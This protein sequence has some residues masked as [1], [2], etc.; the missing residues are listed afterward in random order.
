MSLSVIS[1]DW[2]YP[3]LES[4]S[5]SLENP[6]T[7]LSYPA[8]WLLDMLNGGRTDSGIRVSELTA[9]QASVFLAGVDIISSKIAALDRH[10][11]QRMLSKGGRTV[12]RIARENDYYDLIAIEPNSEMNGNTLIKAMMCHSI[13][14]G[15]AYVELQR[16]AGNTVVGQ[17][18][19]NPAKTWLRRLTTDTRLPAVPW[20]PFPVSIG[21]G[22]MVC[23]TT[24]HL[25]VPDGAESGA[26][27]GPPR[28]IPMADI[29]HIPGLA[30]DGRVGQSTV[31]LARQT[32]GLWLA[33]EKFGSKYFANFARPSGILN[34]PA[35]SKEQRD[36][37]RQSWREAQGGENMLGV[38]VM[39]PGYTWQSM[40][41]SPR[42]AQSVELKKFTRSEIGAVLHI[43][44]HMLGEES[45]SRG[46]TEQLAQELKEY[47]LDPWLSQI[48]MEYKRKLFPNPESSGIGRRPL[49]NA[50]FMDFD[51]SDLLRPD[52]AA[53]DKSYANGK[54]WGYFSTNDIHAKEKM[55]PVD[56]DWADEYWMPIN[57]TLVTTPVDPTH[58]DG[59]GEGIVPASRP[60]PKKKPV[61]KQPGNDGNSTASENR[62]PKNPR[63][64]PL[65]F[66]YKRMFFDAFNRIFSSKTRD[67]HAFNSCFGPV[68]YTIR[69][70]IETE[71]TM[72][73]QCK[74]ASNDDS[75]QYVA[76]YLQS[77]HERC[78]RREVDFNNPIADV[79]E[80]ELNRAIRAI[81]VRVY[82]EV[83][84]QKAEEPIILDGSPNASI[85]A[86]E[87][88]DEESDGER[89]GELDSELA[90]ERE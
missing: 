46:S 63:D 89:D 74:L 6:Q 88:Q 54:Q 38:A 76:L 52:A 14:W 7:P 85:L 68:L 8:E 36:Q 82:Q 29:I 5:G 45:R 73:M 57:M 44:T 43:P 24:D 90:E 72:E 84:Q 56:E 48:R 37:A 66:A 71:A 42:E 70:L 35:I 21:K 25:E 59:M 81:R 27:S 67:L 78:D 9:F 55:N 1:R 3:V 28:I 50:Y 15:N 12:H 83:A 60:K 40:A 22:T 49:P 26:M 19:R 75:T 13:A 87:E 69:D 39:P 65:I 31:W 86:G 41:N 53:R 64:I 80:D 23:M 79:V 20:R 32:L 18:P 61:K 77:L 16:D 2:S 47:C 11:Y 51:L 58:Q 30:L 62:A 10:I 34:T 17:W 33:M 4:R